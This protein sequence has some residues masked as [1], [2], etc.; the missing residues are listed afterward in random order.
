[1]HLL[2]W[3]W[4]S[5]SEPPICDDDTIYEQSFEG[6]LVL[7]KP[8]PKLEGLQAALNPPSSANADACAVRERGFYYG[9]VDGGDA[10]AS[11]HRLFLA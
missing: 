1:V 11:F 3:L 10:C 5:G 7:W 4:T 8:K 2:Y 6:C 9:A